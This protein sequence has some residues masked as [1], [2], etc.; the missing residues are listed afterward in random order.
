MIYLRENFVPQ[1]SSFT[2]FKSQLG[3]K[4]LSEISYINLNPSE[5]NSRGPIALVNNFSV[6]IKF[7]TT[8]LVTLRSLNLLFHFIRVGSLNYKGKKVMLY[9]IAGYKRP[10]NSQ[11]SGS[12]YLKLLMVVSIVQIKRPN[13]KDYTHILVSSFTTAVL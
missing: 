13:K 8:C 6:F 3:Y 1:V 12:Y 2:R 5:E 11:S 10:N 7:F 4:F 9:P